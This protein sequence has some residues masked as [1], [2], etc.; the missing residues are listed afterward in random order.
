L[1]FFVA[2]CSSGLHIDLVMKTFI[3]DGVEAVTGASIHT[4]AE[5]LG[6]LLAA[7]HFPRRGYLR[8]ISPVMGQPATYEAVLQG[9]T[10]F[11][12]VTFTIT[13]Q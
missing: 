13:V 9:A 4:A 5:Q 10:K 2:L 3:T 1:H 8:A 6:Q 7:K 12:T 11:K